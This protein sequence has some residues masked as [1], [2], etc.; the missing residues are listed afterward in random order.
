MDVKLYKIEIKTHTR[1]MYAYVVAADPTAAYQA[2]RSFLDGKEI[3]FGDERE[4]QS[5]EVVADST[6]YTTANHILITGDPQ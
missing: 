2:Y 1:W 5:I 4:L 3:C 6:P